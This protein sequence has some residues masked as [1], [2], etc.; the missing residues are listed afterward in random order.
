MAHHARRTVACYGVGAKQP[1]FVGFSFDYDVAQILKDL[2]HK[3]LYQLQTGKR[4]DKKDDPSC[5]ARPAS[6]VLVGPYA[7]VLM[8]HKWI[9]IA[10]LKDRNNPWVWVTKNKGKE[11]EKS[12]RRLDYVRSSR[13]LI[14]DVFGFYQQSLIKAIKTMAKGAIVDD[15]ELD[16][17]EAGKAER[18]GHESDALTHEIIAKLK[19]YTALET[20]GDR[21]ARRSDGEGDRSRHRQRREAPKPLGGGSRRPSSAHEQDQRPEV[22]LG[23]RRR[24]IGGARAP[25]RRRG[26]ARRGGRAFWRTPYGR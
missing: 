9:K 22:R 12:E 3:K 21:R 17:I 2:S 26:S 7:V 18:G 11:N 8:P 25:D 16:I 4:W 24:R 10:K 6:W 13:I 1:S 15:A 5:P 20:Q 23:R 14:E 19:R